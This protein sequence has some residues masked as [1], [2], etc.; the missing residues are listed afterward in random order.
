MLG[1]YQGAISH[2][3]LDDYLNEFVFPL[4]PTKVGL[5]RE[6]LLAVG[7]ARPPDERLVRP[8]SY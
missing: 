5:T 2:Q 1:T 7:T 3:H 6:A 4:Q 8:T